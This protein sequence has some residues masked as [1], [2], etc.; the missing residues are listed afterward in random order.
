MAKRRPCGCEGLCPHGRIERKTPLRTKNP[1]RSKKRVNPVNRERQARRK[2]KGIRGEKME[3]MKHQQCELWDRPDHKCAPGTVAGHH[4]P[5][6]GAGGTDK[7]TTPLCMYAHTRG[8]RAFHNMGPESWQERWDINLEET[9][10]KWERRWQ[11][12]LKQRSG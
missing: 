9:N 12:H 10:A 6:V 3:W 1:L 8:P 5:T 7:D 2:E 11:E 4:H